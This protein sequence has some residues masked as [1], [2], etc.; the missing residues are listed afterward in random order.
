MLWVSYERAASSY[1]DILHILISSA[2]PYFVFAQVGAA[3]AR[4]LIPMATLEHSEGSNA[5]KNAGNWR[6]LTL[7]DRKSI[8]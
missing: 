6:D 5:E 7:V 2:W 1:N 4:I 3:V 8:H